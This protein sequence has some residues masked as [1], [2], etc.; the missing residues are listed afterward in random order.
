MTLYIAAYDTESPDCLEACRKI[1]EVHRRYEIPGTFFITGKTLE[2]NPT[3]YRD[4]LDD[5]LFEVASHTYSHKMLRDHP[6]CGPAASEREIREEIFRGRECVERVFARSCVGLRA[7]CGWDRGLKGAPDIL[8]LID[9]AGFRYV[10]TVAWGPDFTLPS[11]LR[12]PFTYG[13]QGLAD[14]WEFPGHGWHDNLLKGSHNWG[15]R[16]I[17]LFPPLMP[18]T[19]PDDYI[20]TPE[21]EFAVN[22]KPFIDKAIADG[23]TYVSLI[24]HPWSLNMFDPGMEMLDVTFGYVRKR[25]MRTVTF[26]GLLG[27]LQQATE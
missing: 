4:L 19:I 12:E 7:A 23:M 16:R 24:W 2:A 17:L 15:P 6:F 8:R 10:S 25:G 27:E 14:L 5:P 26:S 1:V 21:E 11:P 18:E 3:E 22:N 13:H 20:E 9:E